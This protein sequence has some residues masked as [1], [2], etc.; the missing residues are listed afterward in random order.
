MIHLQV[1][2][3]LKKNKTAPAELQDLLV[4]T[5]E[6]ALRHAGQPRTWGN[7]P[8][9]D[10]ALLLTDDAQL[11]DLNRTYLGVD[12]PT[13]V[14]AFPGGDI[15]PESERYYLG[16]VV[17][18]VERATEQA[19]AGGHLL[20]AELQLLVVH[21]MLHLCGYDHAD[22]QEKAEMWER[23]AEILRQLDCPIHGPYP[24]IEA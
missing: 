13:D 2:E 20:S 7:Q 14:L 6:K 8:D 22:P 15:D 16:D 1:S 9:A 5:A 23:Q 19:Q 18:S 21:G 3:L 12:A 11:R 4:R 17:I 10:V 24:E